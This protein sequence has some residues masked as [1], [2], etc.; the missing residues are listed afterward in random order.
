MNLTIYVHINT[1]RGKEYKYM[2]I[3]TY[4]QLTGRARY[5]HIRIRTY[6]DM[7]VHTYVDISTSSSLY[8]YE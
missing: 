8:I 3:P 2:Y 1:C 5:E 4:K 7:P 6:T